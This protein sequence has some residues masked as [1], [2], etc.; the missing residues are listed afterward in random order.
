[1]GCSKEVVELHR[2]ADAVET[3]SVILF[4]KALLEKQTVE[5]NDG[6]TPHGPNSGG[7]LGEWRPTKAKT[8]I[9]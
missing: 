7:V 2:L 4:D 3:T 5:D 1:M 8:K 9:H 6:F